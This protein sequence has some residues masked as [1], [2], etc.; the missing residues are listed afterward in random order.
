MNADSNNTLNISN[1]APG[2]RQNDLNLLIPTTNIAFPETTTVAFSSPASAE[3]IKTGKTSQEIGSTFAAAA[4]KPSTITDEIKTVRYDVHGTEASLFVCGS[5]SSST[6]SSTSNIVNADCQGK[7]ETDIAS[8]KGIKSSECPL[9]SYYGSLSD[10]EDGEADKD[11]ERSL[12]RKAFAAKRLFYTKKNSL[13]ANYDTILAQVEGA[14][15]D[16]NTMVRRSGYRDE[17]HYISFGVDLLEEMEV[18][19]EQSGEED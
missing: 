12:K 5:S 9:P 17:Q 3:S 8:S 13:Q 19:E 14:N 16:R 11:S 6:S 15:H 18:D 4:Y 10:D 2:I 1:E 7:Q